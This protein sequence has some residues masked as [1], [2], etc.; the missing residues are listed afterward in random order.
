MPKMLEADAEQIAAGT[1]PPAIEVKAIEDCTVDG[2]Q[3]RN[4]SPA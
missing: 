3:Q 2:R 1:L 4:I